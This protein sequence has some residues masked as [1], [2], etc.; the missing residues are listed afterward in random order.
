MTLEVRRLGS[1]LAALGAAMHFLGRRRP[2]A[3]FRAAVLIDT[4]HG[5]VARD[6]YLVAL[7]GP[8]LSAYV[9]WATLD[10]AVAERLA[11]GGGMPTQTEAASGGEVIWVLTV[12][13]TSRGA[14]LACVNQL[15]ALYPGQRVM[16]VRHKQHGKVVI[17]DQHMRPPGREPTAP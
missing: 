11:R 1:P 9:G 8:Q 17:F 16:G 4:L 15:R 13:A 5:Q 12:A 10:T 14:L 7:E 2:F 3:D 6:H